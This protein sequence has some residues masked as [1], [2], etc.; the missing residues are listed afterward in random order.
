[1]YRRICAALRPIS[2][3][4][5]VAY[6]FPLVL[7]CLTFSGCA[8]IPKFQVNGTVADQYVSTTVDSELSKYYLEHYLQNDHIDPEY[9]QRIE[10]ALTVWN[11]APL[12]RDTLKE[13]TEQFSP[14][15]ATLY[16]VSRIYQDP[17][18]RRAQQA[19]YSHLAA[20]RTKGEE[21]M[22]RVARRF[23]SY[24]IVFVPGYGY[25]QN[26]ATG[27][28]FA[29]Q[30]RIMNRAGFQTR[31]IETEEVGTVEKNASILAGE[32]PRLGERYGNVILVS[33][34]KGGPEVALAIGKLMTPD[35]LNAV[36]AWISIGGLL[37][38]SPEADQ[39]LTWPTSWL[40]RIAFL[41]EGV[42]IQTVKSLHTE[43]RRAVFAQLDF[44]QH[45]VMLQYVGVPLSGQIPEHVEGRYKGLRRLGPNDG[46]TLLADELIE[47]GIVVTDVGL[48]HYYADPEIDLKTF[49]LAQVVMDELEN[50]K[51]RGLPRPGSEGRDQS[52]SRGKDGGGGMGAFVGVCSARGG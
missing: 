51:H 38:G 18:N 9:D 37:R 46:L 33:T 26:P 50:R 43:K 42:P 12:D 39:A 41:F 7:L 31:L 40:A 16:F 20:I 13:I 48:D 10:K 21:E 19:F 32:V 11:Q 34:S 24:L 4:R 14:D 52:H 49:A 8:T 2:S 22:S 44:P 28:D 3:V 15:F 35:Q 5:V 1:M 36:K 27:A 6:L 45:I 30:R 47:G 23:Q 29:R 25:K 17:V